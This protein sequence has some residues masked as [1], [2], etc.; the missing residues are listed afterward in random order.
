MFEKKK[1]KKK[2]NWNKMS[3]YYNIFHR[4]PIKLK[5]LPRN[6]RDPGYKE[7]NTSITIIK[8]KS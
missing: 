2:K 6:T 7:Y 3:L 1:K 4:K 8:K 5:T